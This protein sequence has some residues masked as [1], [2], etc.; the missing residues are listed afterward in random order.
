MH[1]EREGWS[2]RAWGEGGVECTCMGRGR[3]GVYVHGEREGVAYG[4]GRVC[5][6]G[7]RGVYGRGRVC[8]HG[9]YMEGWSMH[10]RGED[11]CVCTHPPFPHACTLDTFHMHTPS[12]HARTLDP[13]H[14]HT[15]FLSPCT[16]SNPSIY[17]HPSSPRPCTLDPFHVAHTLPLPMH[18]H[19][20]PSIC[21]HPLS[22]HT[23]STL[24]YAHTLSPS[25]CTHPP[26][27]HARTL[28]CLCVT[29]WLFLVYS[30]QNETPYLYI[31]F[32]MYIT[33][34]P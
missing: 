5:V 31:G 19:L 33:L 1:G 13:F 16:H 32:Q 10:G 21:T 23:H 3:G 30:F 6:H 24:P 28:V 20:T 11:V 15:P 2:V 7:E 27:P 17:T 4:S 12:P 26:S 22:M 8:V 18:T 29:C 25:I 14:M 34:G 9:V